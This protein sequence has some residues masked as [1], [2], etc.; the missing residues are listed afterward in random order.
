MRLQKKK[1]SPQQ[2]GRRT[3]ANLFGNIRQ[4]QQQRPQP[5]P[6]QSPIHPVI[7][8][9]ASN[10]SKSAGKRRPKAIFYT[11]NGNIVP[12]Y[13]ENSGSTSLS[14]DQSFLSHNIQADVV[15]IG[16]DSVV[17]GYT[18]QKTTTHGLPILR[19]SSSNEENN[20]PQFRHLPP[21]R[22]QQQPTTV[23]LKQKQALLASGQSSSDGS[24][25]SERP[26]Q[27]LADPPTLFPSCPSP[28]A[29]RMG[30]FLPNHI[31]KNVRRPLAH[32]DC[33]AGGE[34]DTSSRSAFGGCAAYNDRRLQ[35][36][37]TE[38]SFYGCRVLDQDPESMDRAAVKMEFDDGLIVGE[39]SEKNSH[40]TISTAP[41]AEVAVMQG[42]SIKG[43]LTACLPLRTPEDEEQSAVFQVQGEKAVALWAKQASAPPVEV[44]FEDSVYQKQD[45]RKKQ[46]KQ[47]RIFK[48]TSDQEDSAMY[49]DPPLHQ[50]AVDVSF[51]S[52]TSSLETPMP[53]TPS[54][55]RQRLSPLRPTTYSSKRT[56]QD[57]S[58]QP[59]STFDQQEADTRTCRSPALSIY[60][61]D[62]DKEEHNTPFYHRRRANSRGSE[63]SGGIKD[64]LDGPMTDDEVEQEV[65]R[66]RRQE[67]SNFQY[68]QQQEHLIRHRTH[69]QHHHD[70]SA[71]VVAF[72]QRELTREGSALSPPE[73]FAFVRSL[74][75]KQI[76]SGHVSSSLAINDVSR[77]EEESIATNDNPAVND[78]ATP[79]LD[80]PPR[81]KTL[82]RGPNERENSEDQ[83]PKH[84]RIVTDGYHDGGNRRN[85][86][87]DEKKDE[88]PRQR[89]DSQRRL[90]MHQRSS[91]TMSAST[92]S[93]SRRRLGLSELDEWL[94]AEYYTDF[95]DTALSVADSSA[96]E[97]QNCMTRGLLNVANW[98][99]GGS[100]LLN[101]TD[102]NSSYYVGEDGSDRLSRSFSTSV[103]V[104]V[105]GHAKHAGRIVKNMNIS[106]SYSIGSGISSTLSGS[107]RQHRRHHSYGGGRTVASRSVSSALVPQN[108]M[109]QFGSWID[110]D[111]TYDED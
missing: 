30:T 20:E 35:N 102:D 10:R 37:S 107:V 23:A 60:D 75:A 87:A 32:V 29:S 28:A 25:L 52:N 38:S 61:A 42:T 69:Q 74:S 48:E 62:F 14:D 54:R 17:S 44:S 111:G 3:V 5:Q 31:N 70:N 94:E 45:Q 40:N 80:Y 27:Q 51:E 50:P 99:D 64:I 97:P 76:A 11:V 84:V 34:L 88:Y 101:D 110:G 98:M 7:K 86:F 73:P 105:D 58:V 81:L 55:A 18:P 63:S 71:D 12:S 43:L 21:T 1:T 104:S 9:R 82:L 77:D 93:R 59:R 89:S 90:M 68:Q 2:G 53:L 49:E 103:N 108:C 92:S 85:Y 24:M 26:K 36:T 79:S 19:N 78:S 66:R 16:T 41:A 95:R 6:Q 39:S 33:P 91:S 15:E 8:E 57:L 13:R 47:S 106:S 83:K 100:G 67:R 109:E 46:Q 4:K 96:M 72:L 56:V 65:P 22:S